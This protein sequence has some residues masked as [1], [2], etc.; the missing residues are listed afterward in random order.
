MLVLVALCSYH[1]LVFLSLSH[2]ALDQNC[3]NRFHGVNRD[4]MACHSNDGIVHFCFNKIRITL[5]G[6]STFYHIAW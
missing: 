1:P 5:I 4:V 2:H 3:I 6:A